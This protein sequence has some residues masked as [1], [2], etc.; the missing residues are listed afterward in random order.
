M[1]A[2][3]ETWIGLRQ[4]VVGMPGGTKDPD[5]PSQSPSTWTQRTTASKCMEYKTGKSNISCNL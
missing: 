5:V 2:G 4:T 3:T 1:S